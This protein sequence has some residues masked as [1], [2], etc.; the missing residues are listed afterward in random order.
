MDWMKIGGHVI[1]GIGLIG[2]VE[3]VIKASVPISMT[4]IGVLI[5]GSVLLGIYK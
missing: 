5:L 2:G 1:Y 3:G 4:A